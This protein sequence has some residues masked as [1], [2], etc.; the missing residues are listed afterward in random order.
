M[1]LLTPLFCLTLAT[2]HDSLG[3]TPRLPR[4]N[5]RALVT[6]EDTLV[7]SGDTHLSQSSP[8]QNFGTNGEMRVGGTSRYR[9]LVQFDSAAIRQAVGTGQLDSARVEFTIIA[10]PDGFGSGGRQVDLHRLTRSWTELGATWNC[11]VDANTAN[12]VADCPGTGWDMTNQGQAPYVTTRTAR[13]TITNG[14]TG[15]I[16]LDVTPD[17][18]AFLA[19]TA[20][21]GWIFR[22]YNEAEYGQALVLSRTTADP[23]RLILAVTTNPVPPQAPDSVPAAIWAALHDPTNLTTDSLLGS[24]PFPRNM[25]MLRFVPGATLQQRQAAIDLIQGTVV[26]G[27]RVFG[28]V[29]YYFVQIQHDGTTGPLRAAIAALSTLP[30]VATAMVEVAEITPNWL[31]PHDGSGWNA[32]ATTKSLAG[33]Q[34]WALERINGPLAWGCATQA[35]TGSVGVIDHAFTALPELTSNMDANSLPAFGQYPAE[36]H[37]TAVASILSA[38]GDNGIGITG[39]LWRSAV[40]LDEYAGAHSNA[41]VAMLR[42]VSRVATLGVRVINLSEGLYWQK[43]FGR[44]PNPASHG[45][46]LT[47]RG[48]LGEFS[49]LVSDLGAAGYQPLFVIGASN[50]G[51]DA[52]WSGLAG[53]EDSFPAQALIVSAATSA[54]SL[55]SSSNRGPRVQV[56]A[57]GEGVYGLDPAGQPTSLSGTSFAAPYAT[58]IAGLLLGIDPSLTAG[59]LDSLIVHGALQGTY[60]ANGIPLVDA[61]ESLKLAAERSGT[62]LCGNRVWASG[63]EIW[64]S[65]GAS[66]ER[67]FTAPDTV[68]LLNVRHGG[69]RIDFVLN[70]VGDTA[71]VYQNGAWNFAPSLASPDLPNATW[72]SLNGMTHDG[73]SVV[74]VQSVP[75]ATG[76]DVTVSLGTP[77]SVGRF[78]SSFSV[79]LLQP[80][81]ATGC[82]TETGSWDSTGTFLGYTC[83]W[84]VS[85]DDYQTASFTRT[86]PPQA[87]IVL[88]TVNRDRHTFLGMSAWL[89]CSGDTADSQGNLSCRTRQAQFRQASDSAL[90]RSVPWAGGVVGPVSW[91]RDSRTIHW[92]GLAEDGGSGV[93]ATS[94]TVDGLASNCTIEYFTPAAGNL[95]TTPDSVVA[96]PVACAARGTGGLAPLRA[97]SRRR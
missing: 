93:M 85:T 87:G 22:K 73:D 9:A 35:P 58:G 46:S 31:A 69:R 33:G 20:H 66:K 86:V 62:P 64:A 6:V 96:N 40:V 26:G 44:P 90:I 43:Q 75:T 60:S 42:R 68:G 61:Y 12:S 84:M 78:L 23:P 16:R 15:V 34:N 83:A 72:H 32:W 63:P 89:P 70:G 48:I 11:P 91:G 2:C 54:G 7:A 3:P 8:N 79:P 77:F 28:N 41:T 59:D 50:D 80:G 47:V 24:A 81:G 5:P 13:V 45:D 71:I 14:Q 37:G 76:R 65:R 51:V 88:V 17:V 21:Q 55:S 56:A 30:A 4:G 10:N 27:A 95:L 49:T 38:Q 82:Q 92:L 52:W 53:L 57:P 19:G 29:E 74:I 1:L 18:A 39:V 97:A 36:G 67:I 25:I 94:L